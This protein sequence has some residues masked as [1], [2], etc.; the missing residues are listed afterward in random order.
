M[1]K[2]KVTFDCGHGGT[3]TWEAPREVV[4]PGLSD[5]EAGELLKAGWRE[6]MEAFFWL[7]TV[8]TEAGGAK[9]T[10]GQ[11]ELNSSLKAMRARALRRHV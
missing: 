9:L 4:R 8:L 1:K 10:D 7:V 5:K 6:S 3:I 2:V 11:R